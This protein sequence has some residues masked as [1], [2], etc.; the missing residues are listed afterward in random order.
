MNDA[1][2]DHPAVTDAATPPNRS[3][4]GVGET[5]Y[6]IGLFAGAL[7]ALTFAAPHSLAGTP[8][9]PVLLFF[10]AF[11]LFTISIGY[12]HPVF[13]HVS[14]DRVAQVSSILV[15]GPVDAA[16]VNGL[17]SVIYP[18]HR[19][20]KGIALPKVALAALTNAG[21][22]SLMVLGGGLMYV[23]IGGEVPLTQIGLSA[24]GAVL[25]LLLAMQVINEA[26]MMLMVRMRPQPTHYTMSLSDTAT[27]LMAGLVAVLVAIVWNRMEMQVFVLL[28][29]VLA[30]G[31]LALKNFAEM[32]MRLERLVDARTA[33]L[34]EKTQQL[35]RLVAR[36]PL[37]GLF[38]R[39]HA[40]QFL[41][42]EVARARL[43][44]HPITVALGDID[45]FK[46]INDQHSHGVGDRVLAQVGRILNAQLRDGD[47][48]ARYGGEEFVFCFIGIDEA[49]AARACEDLRLAVER[50]DW[51]ALSPGL[52]VTMSIGVACSDADPDAALLLE[53]ADSCL[54]RA[55]RLGRNRV[56][57]GTYR[58]PTA[59]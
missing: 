57:I 26:G 20:R 7:V 31:M 49:A 59:A 56:E 14:F 15:L 11:G 39:R 28:L 18:W 58:R 4:P 25:L 38:N 13:G 34:H 46:Q 8:D 21:L 10:I 40:D 47:L 24:F 55:K 44:Q 52:R 42:R 50:D 3:L 29:A 43:E 53:H 22:M 1:R 37:T 2:Q 48:V 16:W 23:A 19:L 51:S 36:D 33:A 12:A 30:A 41:L 5:L 27:E 9:W 32:R 54:Y 6:G 35:E 45:H 17:A